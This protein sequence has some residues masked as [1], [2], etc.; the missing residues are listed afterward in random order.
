MSFGK[1]RDDYFVFRKSAKFHVPYVSKNF[2]LRELCCPCDRCDQTY[3]RLALEGLVKLQRTRTAWNRA[4]E[5][6]S[7]FRC[8]YWN[9]QVGGKSNSTHLDGAGYDIFTL[10]TDPLDLARCA[11][12]YGGFTN[13]G[14]NVTG[15]HVDVRPFEGRLRLWTYEGASLNNVQFREVMEKDF[16]ELNNGAF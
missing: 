12:I 16:E 5:V 2:A 3:Q 4:I 14:L 9:S 8:P 13:I 1:V 6:R 10:G 15:I 11:L 7:G